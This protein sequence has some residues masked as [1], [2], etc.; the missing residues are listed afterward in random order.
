MRQA[1]C[2][3]PNSPIH[4]PSLH[5]L[6]ST[7]I[8][9]TSIQMNWTFAARGRSSSSVPADSESQAERRIGNLRNPHGG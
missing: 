7:N 9:R 1:R 2:N 8:A 4:I 6:D 3:A 5:F